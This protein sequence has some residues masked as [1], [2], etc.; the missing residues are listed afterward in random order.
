M[1][2]NCRELVRFFDE[3]GE[4]RVHSNAIK[5]LSGEELAFALM[6]DYFRRSNAEAE[7]LPGSCTTG[8]RKGPRL[9]GWLKVVEKSQTALY[10]VEVKCWSFHGFNSGKPFPLQLDQDEKKKLRIS[11][12]NRYWDTDAKSIYAKSLLAKVLVPMKF[13]GTPEADIRPMACIWDAVHPQGDD[14]PFFS[15]P[16][17]EKE[18]FEKL[19]VFSMSAYLRHV[20]NTLGKNELELF[21]PVTEKRLEYLSRIFNINIQV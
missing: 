4:A 12:W 19:Y 18:K 17:A 5:T 16:L 9:D 15:V 10:Q 14:S 20:I 6:I 7:K 13:R 1:K 11:K 3:D 8:E 2:L 21:L